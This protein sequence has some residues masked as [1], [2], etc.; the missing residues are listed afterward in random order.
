MTIDLSAATEG[1]LAALTLADNQAA[2]AEIMRRHRDPV[3]RL[4]QAHTGNAND[5]LDIVQDSF[6]AAFVHMRRYDGVR[7]MRAWLARIAINKARDWRRRAVVRGL[8]GM[9][10]GDSGGQLLSVADERPLADQQLD[11]GVQLDRVSAAIAKLPDKLK[12][13]LLLRTIEAL[14]QA[15]TAAA[16]GISQKAVETR[17][18]RARIKLAEALG[19]RAGKNT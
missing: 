1:E 15:E 16:L 8:L 12:E 3:F 18:R 17:V 4:I 10:G 2:F 14:S 5:A 7:P 13:P 19:G 9:G 6:V 11:D